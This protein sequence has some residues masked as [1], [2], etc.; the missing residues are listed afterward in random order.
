VHR[1]SFISDQTGRLRGPAAEAASQ[2]G[3]L[4]EPTPPLPAAV[5]TGNRLAAGQSP[6]PSLVRQRPLPRPPLQLTAH[7]PTAL[8][9]PRRTA[10]PKPTRRSAPR[11]RH[12]RG[13]PSAQLLILCIGVRRTTA[14]LTCQQLIR[15]GQGA[16]LRWPIAGGGRLMK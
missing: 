16:L 2:A 9:T 5:G 15:G 1:T 11:C 10:R 14:Y 13:L 3:V 12:P 7:T 4:D 8:G 6:V